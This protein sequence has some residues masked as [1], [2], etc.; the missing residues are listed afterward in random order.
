MA[1]MERA[2]SVQRTQVDLQHGSPGQVQASQAQDSGFARAYRHE[3]QAQPGNQ[4]ALRQ[5]AVLRGK[6]GAVYQQA[7]P[8]AA[9]PQAA[10]ATTPP[11]PEAQPALSPVEARLEALPGQRNRQP[12]EGGLRGNLPPGVDRGNELRDVAAE[13]RN[14]RAEIT[15]LSRMLGFP[16]R[17][18]PEFRGILQQ[19]D[20]RDS[21]VQAERYVHEL[22]LMKAK[23]ERTA[24]LVEQQQEID[25]LS[26]RNAMERIERRQHDLLLALQRAESRLAQA[27][28]TDDNLRHQIIGEIY[29]ARY[30]IAVFGGMRSAQL[31]GLNVDQYAA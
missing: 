25:Q 20:Q 15:T 28:D 24:G 14:I 17:Q 4:E 29:R 7:Q 23:G 19:H 18:I 31:S 13:L 3:A 6:S 26:R 21:D 30:S 2:Q 9:Q 11:P 10:T 16:S 27:P 22:P 8:E 12:L 5:L 1:R